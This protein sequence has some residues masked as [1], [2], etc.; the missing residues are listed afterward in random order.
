MARQYDSETRRQHYLTRREAAL[1]SQRKWNADNAHHRRAH[2]ANLRASKWGV[3]GTLTEADVKNAFEQA[4]GKCAYCTQSAD[5]IDHIVPMSRGGANVPANIVA[6]C[7]SCNS[8]K[9]NRTVREWV[10]GATV[11]RTRKKVAMTSS[12]R[13]YLWDAIAAGMQ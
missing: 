3:V 9:Y 6:C 5:T 10:D 8:K 12:G 1:A 11:K 2:N 13:V 4:G 7:L